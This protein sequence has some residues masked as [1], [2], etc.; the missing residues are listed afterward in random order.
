ML[1][2][3]VPLLIFFAFS[4]FALEAKA[5]SCGPKRSTYDAYHSAST[6][7]VGKAI[8]SMDVP[9]S[10]EANSKTSEFTIPVF[11]FNVIESFKEENG[12]QVDVSAGIGSFS[13]AF[14]TG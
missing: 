3:L 8:G 13:F 6:V 5:C 14:T 1:T 4:H 10:R 12:P 11:Q 9:L 7:F 2:R